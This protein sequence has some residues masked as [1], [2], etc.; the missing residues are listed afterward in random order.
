[1][2]NNSA[3]IFAN[4]SFNGNTVHYFHLRILKKEKK[5][6]LKIIYMLYTNINSIQLDNISE[7]FCFQ[8]CC[9]FKKIK[10]KEFKFF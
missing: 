6:L 4:S 10:N 3:E 5:F 7:G 9:S 8:V 2:G 1:M